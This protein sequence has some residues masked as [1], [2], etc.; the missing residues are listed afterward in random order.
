MHGRLRLAGRAGCK[1]KQR[2]VI[3]AGRDGVEI[4]RR[5]PM[6]SWP[7]PPTEGCGPLT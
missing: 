5:L 2:N 7:S 1:T 3:A 6:R 4:A